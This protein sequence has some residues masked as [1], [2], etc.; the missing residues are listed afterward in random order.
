MF[1]FF[2]YTRFPGVREFVDKLIGKKKTPQQKQP[3]PAIPLDTPR[4]VDS[5]PIGKKYR[6][7]YVLK[8]AYILEDN[9]DE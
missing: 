9:K 5:P 6:E 3:I 4:G 2:A 8:K 1:L 7:I